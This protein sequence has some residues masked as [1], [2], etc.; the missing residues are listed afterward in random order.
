MSHIFI[1]K[2]AAKGGGII[3]NLSSTLSSRAVSQMCVYCATK[4]R[5]NPK[6]ECVVVDTL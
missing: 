2:M 1:P 6:L 4:V 5:V 3:I